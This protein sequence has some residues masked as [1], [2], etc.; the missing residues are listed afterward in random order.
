MS[1]IETSPHATY[2]AH[3]ERGELAYQYSAAAGRAVFFPRL[4]C[5]F[6]GTTDLEWR[7]ASGLGRSFGVFADLVFEVV[8]H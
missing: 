2:V 6:T 8:G 4:V 5:P 1:K 3:L 7:V